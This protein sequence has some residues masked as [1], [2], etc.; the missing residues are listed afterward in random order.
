MKAFATENKELFGIF[1]E[2]KTER[3]ALEKLYVVEMRQ[4][5]YAHLQSMRTDRA[6]MCK[7]A[8]KTWKKKQKQENA[9][10]K[11]REERQYM[12]STMIEVELD[13]DEE[14]YDNGDFSLNMVS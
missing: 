12:D 5:E 7:G 14:V 2:E 3:K 9:R 11:E 4:D 1:C 10:L 6:G 8:D 13:S